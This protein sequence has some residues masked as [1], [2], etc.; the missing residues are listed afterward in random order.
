MKTVVAKDV[1]RK[2]YVAADNLSTHFTTEVRNWLVGNPDITCHRA[3]LGGSSSSS[4]SLDF[5]CRHD[6]R[7]GSRE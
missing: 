7:Y 5:R 2:L 4:G 1:D 3:A 6:P